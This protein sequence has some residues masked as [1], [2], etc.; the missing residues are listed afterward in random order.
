VV[1]GLTKA[2]QTS[3]VVPAL[4]EG[5]KSENEEV[6]WTSAEGLAVAGRGVA[7]YLPELVAAVDKPSFQPVKV[8]K[9]RI[10]QALGEAGEDA[11]PALPKLYALLRDKEPYVRR[12]A[13]EALVKAGAADPAETVK[14]VKPFANDPDADTRSAVGKVIEAFGTNAADLAVSLKNPDLGQAM[15][16]LP[17]VA[18]RGPDADVLVPDLLALAGRIPPP[19]PNF[20]APDDLGQIAR[21]LA[22]TGPKAAPALAEGL[23]SNNVQIRRVSARALEK[24]GLDALGALTA[25]RAG[26]GDAD[27]TVRIA[28]ANALNALGYRAREAAPDL[29]KSLDA[30]EDSAEAVGEALAWTGSTGED[31]KKLIEALKAPGPPR[32]RRA[33]IYAASGTG[34]EAR[35]ILDAFAKELPPD[36]PMRDWINGARTIADR[37]GAFQLNIPLLGIKAVQNPHE[38]AGRILRLELNADQKKKFVAGLVAALDGRPP[39]VQV[40]ILR[41]LRWLGPDA[42][43]ALP[44]VEKLLAVPDESV[45]LAETWAV[46]QIKP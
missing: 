34:K 33:R 13:L 28:S 41:I 3:L 18:R 19:R 31:A 26:V 40:E 27:R 46:K 16:A 21:V 15:R 42:S 1:R 37:D 24:M 7:K 20:A 12:A 2:G 5:L 30:H 14:Q 36:D 9:L 29:I 25:L 8:G 4:V 35:A 22:G 32:V 43:D 11:K 10:I 39:A 38:P 45:R 6:Q 44:A 17:T 23:K